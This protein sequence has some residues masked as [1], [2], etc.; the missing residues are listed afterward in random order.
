MPIIVNT[1]QLYDRDFYEFVR[2]TSLS[3]AE[4]IV[5][6]LINTLSPRSVVDVGCGE[7][8][9]LSVFARAGV[10]RI[11]GFDGD[12]VDGERLLIP[13]NCFVARDL[14]QPFVVD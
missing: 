6:L 13:R 9:W 7:G 8:A 3:S 1:H 12:H 5:P 14:S 11:L 10:R 4:V 2:S